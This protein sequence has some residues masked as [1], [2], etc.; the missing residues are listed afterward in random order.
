MSFAHGS[1]V[2]GRNESGRVREGLG[3]FNPDA[4]I[5]RPCGKA[6]GDA[7]A[8]SPD[9]RVEVCHGGAYRD[10][11][12]SGGGR[13]AHHI[14]ANEVNGLETRDGPCISM[15][16]KDHRK[17]ASC[18]M[19]KEARNYREKQGEL[20]GAGDFKAALKMDIDDI[21]FSN[22][23][24]D[25]EKYKAGLHEAAD[26]AE[27]MGLIPDQEGLWDAPTNSQSPN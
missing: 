26:Y 7:S 6:S 15:D 21:L 23:I 17:T 24:S 25:A 5:E 13:E 2:R 8:F 9:K 19:S 14:P 11:F 4:R 27:R 22:K 3:S 20:I 10:V 18:G 12:I 1:E 16:V